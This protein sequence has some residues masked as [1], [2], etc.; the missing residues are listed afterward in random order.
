MSN[1]EKAVASPNVCFPCNG[2]IE[3]RTTSLISMEAMSYSSEGLFSEAVFA[4]VSIV[5]VNMATQSNWEGKGLFQL[6]VPVYHVGN[7]GRELT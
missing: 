6:L 5:E 2:N 7:S 4:R 3:F 1:L